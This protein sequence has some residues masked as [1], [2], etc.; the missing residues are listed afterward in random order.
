MTEEQWRIIQE[1]KGYKISPVR[2]SRL[3]FLSSSF[4]RTRSIPA[5]KGIAR[6]L[7]NL[8]ARKISELTG[9]QCGKDQDIQGREMG[10]PGTDIRLS[11]T[12]RKLFP[13]SV[14]CKSGSMNLQAA[15]RQAKANMVYGYA[16]WLVV[17]NNPH[18]RRESR[19][20]PVVILDLDLFFSLLGVVKN[21][22]V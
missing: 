16:N 7:Q 3:N 13:F 6:D 4:H 8:V 2:T 19:Q 5:R 12:A 15:I 22:E 10:Q 18:R 1:L 14:E 20:E 11:E 9:L 17:Y 21:G